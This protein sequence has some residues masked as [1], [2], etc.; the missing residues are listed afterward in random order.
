MSEPQ[1]KLERP[2]AVVDLETTGVDV[3]SA[4]IVQFG[5]V[6]INDGGVINSAEELLVNPGM[7]IPKEATAI[8]GITDEMVKDRPTFAQIAPQIF[9]LLA[10]CDLAGFNLE[11]FDLPILVREFEEAGFVGF[12]EER[13]V[14]DAMIIYHLNERRDLSAAVRFY[15]DHDHSDAHTA[16]A[17]ARATADI[18]LEQLKRYDL[19]R[20]A[21]GLHDYCHQKNPRYVDTDGKFVWVAG[22][23]V[24]NFGKCKGARLRDIASDKADYLKWMVDKGD[25]STEVCDII[26]AALEG[27]LPEK[28]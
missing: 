11:R 6:R 23:A 7:P 27:E 16:L 1:L 26:R 21:E 19:P 3:A 20:D 2:I 13:K 22:E 15:L 24:F 18:L 17:D 10:D 12:A 14:V 4:R 28:N 5:M 8:H 9:E 25:F